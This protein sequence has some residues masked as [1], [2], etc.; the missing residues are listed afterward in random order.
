MKNEFVNLWRDW[1]AEYI[2]ALND[3]DDKTRQENMNKVNPSFI[4]RNYLME[5]AIRAAEYGE[6]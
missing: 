2:A 6:F 1:V 5:E 3:S 4:L